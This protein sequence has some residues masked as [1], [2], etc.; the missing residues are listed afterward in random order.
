[1]DF[2]IPYG[3][4]NYSIETIPAALAVKFYEISNPLFI[5]ALVQYV[6]LFYVIKCGVNI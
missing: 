1:M 3:R 5:G 4:S 2:E 6:L